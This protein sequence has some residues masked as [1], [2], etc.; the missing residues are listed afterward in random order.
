MKEHS[1]GLAKTNRTNMEGLLAP[2]RDQVKALQELAEK[3]EPAEVERQQLLL[4]VAAVLEL[5]AMAP[6]R[7]GGIDERPA[8]V[9]EHRARNLDHHVL[10]AAH[11]LKRDGHMGV[12][13][14]AV[15]DD[16]D[17]GQVAKAPVLG[18]AAAE[19]LRRAAGALRDDLRRPLG[20]VGT[21]VAHGDDVDAR[22][23]RQTTHGPSASSAAADDAD[24]DAP[25]RRAPE[26]AHRRARDAG[27]PARTLRG[28]RDDSTRR[29]H[30]PNE[31]LSR[32]HV[33]MI[34]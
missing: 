13:R 24:A 8:L 23:L 19:H 2:V 4:A 32:I 28:D 15:V 26:V 16:I 29:G 30:H 25:H 11:R 5:H 6:S 20:E 1:E 27:A 14:G 12:P 21:D 7:L 9:D 33:P 22:H 34:P 3:T 31:V 10:A 18:I 17:L